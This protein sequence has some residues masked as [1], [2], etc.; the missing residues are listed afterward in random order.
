MTLKTVSIPFLK[1]M[2]ISH[3]RMIIMIR[4][5]LRNFALVEAANHIGNAMVVL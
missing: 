4:L 3:F 2:I 1:V 5:D